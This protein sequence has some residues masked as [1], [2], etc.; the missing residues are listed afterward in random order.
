[1]IKK[2]IAAAAL[3]LMAASSHA[4]EPGKVYAGVD[5]G[6]SRF[7]SAEGK[8]TKTS[9]GAFVGYQLT[10]SFALEGGYRSLYGSDGDFGYHTSADQLSLSVIGSYPL[11]QATS[12][13]GRVGVNR[14]TEKFDGGTFSIRDHITRPL[15]GLGVNYKLTSQVSARLEV[16]RTSRDLTNLSAGV[17]YAF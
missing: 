11:N 3:T 9:Y 10:P 7:D 14:I 8:P 13:Y 4:E 12:I 6:S 2:L 15:I 16:Q 17:S 1:M 5:F